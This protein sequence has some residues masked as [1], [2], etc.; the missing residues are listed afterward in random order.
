MFNIEVL[1]KIGYFDEN[2]Y[3]EDMEIGMR[4]LTDG[5][6]VESSVRAVSYT[7]VPNTIRKLFRQ[8][9]R[10]FS[11][12]FFNILKYRKTALDSKKND[13]WKIALPFMLVS[14]FLSFFVIIG[15]AYTVVVFLLPAYGI[16]LNTSF[17]FLINY[18]I[19]GISFLSLGARTFLELVGAAIGTF[20]IL[21]SLMTIDHKFK[22]VKDFFGI[23]GYMTFYSFFLS[24]IWLY[25]I[26]ALGK[27]KALSTAQETG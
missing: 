18:L 17:S 9:V 2:N 12:F 14:I 13:I 6:K 5:Y 4:I 1:K 8:R 3:T 20:S 15:I 27:F 26:F 19:P 22:A 16:L 25:S 10:W 23:L 11:G 24:F 21:Y 7:V